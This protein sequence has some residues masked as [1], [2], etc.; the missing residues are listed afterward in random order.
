MS[1]FP[2]SVRRATV[3][4]LSAMIAIGYSLTNVAL[5]DVIETP[6]NP[7][8]G[9]LLWKKIEAELKDLAR[10]HPEFSPDVEIKLD[11]VNLKKAQIEMNRQD[12][13]AVI[14]DLL[15]KLKE[16][17][18]RTLQDSDG[19]AMFIKSFKRFR[20]TYRGEDEIV[21]A[22]DLDDPIYVPVKLNPSL[23]SVGL[24]EKMRYAISWADGIYRIYTP[25]SSLPEAIRI[26]AKLP[27]PDWPILLRSLMYD[28]SSKK[29]TVELG[30]YHNLIQVKAVVS[31]EGGN[32]IK[33]SIQPELE[34]I[35]P[36][37][38]LPILFALSL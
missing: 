37:T 4:A 25:G 3:V 9:E 28:P 17:D 5:C 24:P 20:L 30:A 14:G 36:I 23:R 35:L 15:K 1:C 12:F 6:E 19:F 16:K 26:K 33:T 10:E 29:G 31:Q 22:L 18:Q 34:K 21:M 8:R 2:N 38:L 7:N 27:G 11:G 13:L 32:G